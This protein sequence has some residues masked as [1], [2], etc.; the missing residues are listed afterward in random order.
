MDAQAKTKIIAIVGPTSSGKTA[1]SIALAK[2][3][4]AAVISADSRQVYRSMD[5]GTGKVTKREMRGIP[6]YLLGVASPK[7]TFTA[8]EYRTKA[9]R[10]IASI[11]RAGKLPIVCGGT[12]FYLDTLFSDASLPNVRPNI[13]LRKKL[14][15]MGTKNLF[16]MLVK[17]DARRAAT[18]DRNNRRRLIRALEIIAATGKPIPARFPAPEKSGRVLFIGLRPDAK[19]LS[20]NIHDRLI[21]RLRHGMIAEVRRLHEKG[22]VSWKRLDD[23]GLEYRYVSRYIRGMLTKQEMIVR[24]EMEI[25]HY[26]KRQM[27]WFRRNPAIHWIRNEKNAERFVEKFLAAQ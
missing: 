3:Y 17:K 25:R 4:N 2:K 24:L 26:A 1:L 7:R 5:I 11:V 9:R 23:L 10:A 21:A 13:S 18:I 12:G 16:A 19:K 6:H 27:T 22:G 8:A 15:A 20:R 14:N